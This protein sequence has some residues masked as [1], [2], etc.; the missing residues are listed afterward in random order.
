MKRLLF[1]LIPIS[2]MV[3][4]ACTPYVPVHMVLNENHPA[5]TP[6]NS[7]AILV[8]ARQQTSAFTYGSTADVNTFLDED[9]IGQTTIY[10]YFVKQVDPGVHYVLSYAVVFAQAAPVSVAKF[11]FEAGKVYYLT[12]SVR[13]PP[14]SFTTLVNTEPF[15]PGDIDLSG[16]KYMD[17]NAN[18]GA[19]VLPNEDRKAAIKGFDSNPGENQDI[20]NYKGY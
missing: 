7:K 11:D 3:L 20:L 9:F 12:F 1:L 14:A 6:S 4:G 5:I 15:A 19:V 13:S 18:S 8:I 10:S 16:L 17:F 2:I